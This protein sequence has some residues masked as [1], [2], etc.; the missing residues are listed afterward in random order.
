MEIY[1]KA[2]RRYPLAA[3]HGFYGQ[4]YL[5]IVEGKG[6]KSLSFMVKN[7]RSLIKLVPGAAKKS[8]EHFNKAIEIAAEI[9][10]KVLLA[11][12]HLG[13]GLLHRA[14]GK[15]EKARENISKAIE[16]FEEIDADAHLK[17]AKEELASL[18]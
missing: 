1:H 7:I 18:R 4:L 15:T 6:P 14:K 10:A 11:Q 3:S 16:I 9:G 12:A 17:Q 8:E 2:N 5:Q 13:L